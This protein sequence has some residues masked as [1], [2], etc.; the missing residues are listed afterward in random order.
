MKNQVYILLFYIVSFL[1]CRDPYNPPEIQNFDELIVI[2]ANVNGTTGQ[3]SVVLSLSKALNTEDATTYIANA[4]I[5]LQTDAG[6]IY[7]LPYL[8]EGIYSSDDVF[9]AYGDKVQ[10]HVAINS[11]RQ[12]VSEYEEF[13]KTPEID[14]ITYEAD[15]KGL[16]F[17]VSSHDP[18]NSSVYYKWDYF[19]TW[20]FKS[21]FDSNFT[22]ETDSRDNLI[23]SSIT[24]RDPATID[25]MRFC[26]KDHVS[27]KIILG[28]SEDLNE[29]IISNEK[30]FFANYAGGKFRYRYSVLVRQNALTRKSYDYWSIL[31]SNT[32]DVGSI[33]D[34]QPSNFDSNIIN[35]NN[36]EEVVLGYFSVFSETQKRIFISSSDVPK[37]ETNET[38]NDLCTKELL[39]IWDSEIGY[40]PLIEDTNLRYIVDEQ[41]DAYNVAADICCDCRLTGYKE[42]PDFW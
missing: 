27:T 21:A 14:S 10:L 23:L 7:I 22:Y 30:I 26:F 13:I 5:N 31:S 32:E 41:V 29:D 2:D 15:E 3:A 37:H 39:K 33:F 24:P 35:M 11:D 12:Y 16:Q 20:L 17:F 1:G 6:A 34:K 8:D 18:E 38:L 42:T 4:E 36:P 25:S 9:L 40:S 28:T 19:E